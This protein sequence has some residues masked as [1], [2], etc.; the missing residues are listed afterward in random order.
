[1]AMNALRQSASGGLGKFILFGFLV[2]AVGGLVFSDV[3]GFF[4]GGISTSNVAEIGERSISI[5]DFDRSLRMALSQQ[6]ITPQQA[7]EFGYLNQFLEG[8]INAEVLAAAAT[9]NDIVVSRDKIAEQILKMVEPMAGDSQSPQQVLDQLLASQGLSERKMVRDMGTDLAVSAIRDTITSGFAGVSNALIEDIKDY[10]NETRNVSYIYFKNSEFSD[11]IP[12]PEDAE[13]EN[14]YESTKEAYAIPETREG[15]LI[16]IDMSEINNTIEITEEELQNLYDNNVER[17]SSPEKRFIEQVITQ[18]EEKAQ[19]I[20]SSI[21][22]DKDLKTATQEILNSVTD[23]IPSKEVQI[24]TTLEELKD[25]IFSSEQGDVIGPIQS[26]LGYHV[27]VLSKVEPA[28]QASFEEVKQEIENE[29]KSSRL[30]DI[31]YDLS[32]S[33]DDLLAGGATPEEIKNELKVTITELPPMTR[34][35]TSA[36]GQTLTLE[37]FA[38]DK[39][40]IIQNLFDLYEEGEGSAVFDTANDGM[41]AVYLKTITPKSYKPFE[42]LKPVL[43]KR[44]MD[45][46]RRAKNTNMVNALYNKIKNNELGFEEAAKT[47]NKFIYK[48]EDLKRIDDV[49]APLTQDSKATIFG[50]SLKQPALTNLAEGPAIVMVNDYKFTKDSSEEEQAVTN[51]QIKNMLVNSAQQEALTTFVLNEKTKHKEKINYRLLEQAYG[52]VNTLQ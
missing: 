50:A 20:A 47:N 42:E 35:G 46:Q 37:G 19:E 13:L 40:T 52:Q 18:N 44:W 49:A 2:L 26:A 28:A 24:D 27:V 6:G 34:F 21:S 31:R 33:L 22:D 36:E 11:D 30:S 41:A 10:Q 23:Y 45:D 12:L 17:Y 48:L 15:A 7:Y 9:N 8:Q 39:Q 3:G 38:D 43:T 16:S 29:V 32:A 25:P 14:L 4:R 5:Q 1:M 51:E